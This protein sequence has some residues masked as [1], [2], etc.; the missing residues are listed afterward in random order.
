LNPPFYLR[1]SKVKDRST[2]YFVC[3]DTN[4]EVWRCSTKEKI[5]NNDWD[6]GY[7]K[8]VSNTLAV[9]DTID[10]YKVSIKEFIK[11]HVKKDKRQPTKF[12]FLQFIDVLLNGEKTE[13]NDTVTYYIEEYLSDD[14]VFN[15]SSTKRLKK[16]HLDNF[17]KLSGKNKKLI[18]LNK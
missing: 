2:I 16:V 1:K 18:D 5:L 13:H 9:R 6:K 4:G 15:E 14:E 3:A 17:L 10:V 8:K 11:D 12:E 7:P